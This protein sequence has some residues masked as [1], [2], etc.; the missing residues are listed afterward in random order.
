MPAMFGGKKK[1]NADASSN[2]QSN[3]SGQQA[4]VDADGLYQSS[5]SPSAQNNSTGGSLGTI[6]TVT[7]A[8]SNPVVQSVIHTM[9][10]RL[11]AYIHL[12]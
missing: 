10:G 4:S 1:S 9:V 7:S 6:G 11:T 12:D 8:W 3:G 5:F 2:S